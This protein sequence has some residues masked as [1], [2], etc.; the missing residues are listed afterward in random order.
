MLCTTPRRGG[1][2][3]NR[4][5]NHL[6]SHGLN[7]HLTR[8]GFCIHYQGRSSR[9][10]KRQEM[11]IMDVDTVQQGFCDVME[12]MS[13]SLSSVRELIKSL[14]EKCVSF[15]LAILKSLT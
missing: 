3:E 2:L 4:L 9:F 13:R 12:E 5:L 15:S 1:G 8:V 6:F 10:L 11:A 14:R 7:S